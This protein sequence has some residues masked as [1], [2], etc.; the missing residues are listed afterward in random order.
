[1]IFAVDSQDALENLLQRM[2]LLLILI[3]IVNFISEF[4]ELQHASKF[5]FLGAMVSVVYGIVQMVGF[6][7]GIN[8]DI[9]FLDRLPQVETY[10]LGLKVVAGNPRLNAFINDPNI[11]GAYLLAILGLGISIFLAYLQRNRRINLPMLF[12]ILLTAVAL[13]ATLSRSA[14]LGFCVM[15]LVIWY[16][17][18]RQVFRPRLILIGILVILALV[19][20]INLSEQGQA[21]IQRMLGESS[22]SQQSTLAHLRYADAAWEMFREN[23]LTGVG[24]GG[25]SI[26]F[27]RFINPD[28]RTAMSHSMYLTLL[29]ETGILSL[30]A[31]L[32]VFIYLWITLGIS[33][34]K[35]NPWHELR[36]YLI[37]WRA[38]LSGFAVSSIFYSYLSYEFMWC[39]LGLMVASILIAKKIYQN[40]KHGY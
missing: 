36:A 17:F 16:Y 40:Q 24:L 19:T 39:F 26:Y 21:F 37:G 6:Y 27:T 28:A 7:A 1:M 22:A 12:V 25:Y 5:L 29:S 33:I 9:P 35:I 3:V 14:I 13:M 20:L 8:T 30:S 11:L 32:L 18:R 23:P 2:L 10:R 38:Y 4:K 15:L 31:T 34:R